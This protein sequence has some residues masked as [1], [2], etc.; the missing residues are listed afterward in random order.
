MEKSFIVSVVRKS[1]EVK[2]MIL[3]DINLL[4]AVQNQGEWMVKCL[5]NGGTIWFCGNGG[6]AAD[7]QHLAAELSGRF[8]LNRKA[9][10]AEAL[11][12]NTSFLTAVAN[13]FGYDYIYAR[14]IEALGSKG[15]VLVAI[16]TS[17]NSKNIILAVEK[18]KEM[19]IPTFLWSG[20]T[21]GKLA[22]IA[23]SAILVPS[24]DTP[25][26]QEVHITLG[27]IICEW[28]EKEMVRT[29]EAQ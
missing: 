5:R 19:G 6:S 3:S 8:Y 23:D 20:K 4:T 17:G 1:I 22:A 10:A 13:D 24:E 18:A 11:H 26:I 14:A 9:F 2:E 16:S 25:R 7:A 28:I 27:H 29:T 15:D 21:G 12:V